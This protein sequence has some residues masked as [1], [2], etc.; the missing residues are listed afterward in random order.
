MFI[1]AI[2]L[3]ENYRNLSHQT[4]TFDPAVNFLIG[5]NNIGKTNVLELLH[6][7][8]AEAPFEAKDFED[9]EKP[10]CV[11]MELA[12]GETACRMTVR[13]DSAA[14]AASCTWECDG[15]LQAK[16]PKIPVIYDAAARLTNARSDVDGQAAG[17]LWYA[18]HLER[19]IVAI[20]KKQVAAVCTDA[21]GRRYLPLVMILDE[22][23][24]HL[25]PYRQRRLIKTLE[26]MVTGGD[27]AFRERFKATTGI[28]ALKGQIFIATHSPSILLGDYHQFIRIHQPCRSQRIAVVC[29]AALKMDYRLYKHMLHN[30]IYLK[31]AM[32]SHCIVFVE[33]DTEFGAF[34]VF[35]ERYGLDLDAR[36]IGLV[37]LDGADSLRRCM[38]L[39]QA[40]DIQTVAI[41]DRDKRPAYRDEKDVFFTDGD[42]FEADVYDHFEWEDYYRCARTLQKIDAFPFHQGGETLTPAEGRKRMRRL[43]PR[44]L[45]QLKKSK[46]ALRG[47]ILATAVTRIPRSFMRVLAWL[48]AQIPGE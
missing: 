34:P 29:G 30:F 26:A 18:A 35:A 48:D 12:I 5:E 24:I 11:Q 19:R 22:P 42:D 3:I 2:N 36:G 40:F 38:R 10:L 31:E 7:L 41:I 23:E 21:T 27:A 17:K 1:R 33:G 6:H 20:A 46:N 45:E 32:F 43:R 28:D 4:L 8:L 13:Q 44:Q 14:A 15:A 39:Y 37:K 47:S 9:P 25:H 16:K